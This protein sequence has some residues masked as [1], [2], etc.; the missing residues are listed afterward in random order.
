MLAGL[1]GEHVADT[2]FPPALTLCSLCGKIFARWRRLEMAGRR[3][4]VV[5]SGDGS[6]TDHQEGSDGGKRK[7]QAVMQRIAP[8]PSDVR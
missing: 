6:D 1:H 5:S 2:K 8:K 7:S 4:S 3:L